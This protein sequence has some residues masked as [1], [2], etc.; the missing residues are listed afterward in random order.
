MRHAL[1]LA[2][3]ALALTACEQTLRLYA[4]SAT[5]GS[6]G[7]KIGTGG[8]GGG[9]GG[10][11]NVDGGGPDAHCFGSA[12]QVTVIPD[13]P[14]MV[15]L[16]ERSTSMNQPF[17]SQNQTQLSAALSAFQGQWQVYN[18]RIKFSFA[19]FPDLN[20]CQPQNG[21]CSGDIQ[22]D[23]PSFNQGLY[24]CGGSLSSCVSSASRPTG[25]ALASA[26]TALKGA[27]SRPPGQ[28]YVLLITDG[29]PSGGCAT[30]DDCSDAVDKVS[31]L[32]DD[33]ISLSIVGIQSDLGCLD[34]A[35][36]SSGQSA[37]Q[38]ASDPATLASELSGIMQSA[39]CNATLSPMPQ[40]GD[41]QVTYSG[42][43][44][45]PDRFSGW[46]Y[47]NMYGRLHLRGQACQDVLFGW[48]NLKVTTTC[49]SRNPGGSSG[50]P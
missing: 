17:A 12:Q 4:S 20:G 39:V 18:S 31:M 22:T 50:P 32:N 8:S 35:F 28:R 11:G 7:G 15:V 37:V 44:I 38:T 48:D 16:F 26:D 30:K 23:W 1:V 5:G 29:P 6:G 40:S 33:K 13:S 34:F 3:A 41:L 2:T 27:N 24:A 42:A 46:T 10:S 25:T 19:E 9:S 45:P 43:T 21:C 49:G 47:D 36:T 14:A